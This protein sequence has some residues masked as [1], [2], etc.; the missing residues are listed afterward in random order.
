MEEGDAEDEEDEQN[1]IMDRRLR[2]LQARERT[3]GEDDEDRFELL[4]MF[5]RI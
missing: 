3:T 4:C 2:R 1:E 5:V